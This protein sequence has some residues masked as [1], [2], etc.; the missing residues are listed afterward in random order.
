MALGG[1]HL[2]GGPLVILQLVAWAG[3]LVSYSMEDGLAEGVKD[4]FSGERPCALCRCIDSA[5]EKESP[6]VLPVGEDQRRLAEGL[7]QNLRTPEVT[8]LPVP[9]EKKWN[10]TL[11][12][13]VDCRMPESRRGSPETPPPQRVG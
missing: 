2:I 11:V 7:G 13:A 8:D 9:Q 12:G 10:K 4:T 6:P 5:E 3:M 1:A